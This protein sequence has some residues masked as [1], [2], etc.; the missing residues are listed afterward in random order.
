MLLYNYL[1]S[2]TRLKCEYK[3][4]SFYCEKVSDIIVTFCYYVM[5]ELNR[6][7][8][9]DTG[10]WLVNRPHFLALC[11][12]VKKWQHILNNK[13]KKIVLLLNLFPALEMNNFLL[14]NCTFNFTWNYDNFLC[15]FKLPSSAIS[16][17]FG[18]VQNTTTTRNCD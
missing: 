10:L 2:R 8:T 6:M 14:N 9:L 3:Y 16:L 13:S 15:S 4:V 1:Y 5:A 7:L 12:L 18:V 11:H 17:F